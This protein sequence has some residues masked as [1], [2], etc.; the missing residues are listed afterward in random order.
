MTDFLDTGLSALRSLDRSTRT[1]TIPIPAQLINAYLSTVRE[2]NPEAL[3]VFESLR[4]ICHEGY[5]EVQADVEHRGL[6]AHVHAALEILKLEA[7]LSSEGN[8]QI[9]LLRRRE[10]A[11]QGKAWWDRVTLLVI[12]ALLATFSN[13]P[14]DAWALAGVKGI[15]I[16]D[17]VYTI[18]IETLGIRAALITGIKELIQTENR[19]MHQA[20]EFGVGVYR[21]T[22]ARCQANTL[23]LELCR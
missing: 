11:I 14:L 1:I 20:L 9:V 5:I 17:D 15:T 21:L 6:T 22:G 3:G 19:L 10:T 18:D 4:L 23:V 13:S 2:H 7:D 12:Q 8:G 16:A